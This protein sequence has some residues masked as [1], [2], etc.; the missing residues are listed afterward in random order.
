MKL[1]YDILV[2][3]GGHA[4]AE[5]AWA[6]SRLGAATA[7]ITLSPTR[8]GQMSCNPA[9]GG[10]AKGQMVREIDALGGLMGIA[11]DST[12]IQFR[13]L[14]RSKGPAVWGPR[15]Q[16]DKYKYATE[17]QRLLATCP[18]LDIIAGE[19]ADIEV[20]E[21]G[22]VEDADPTPS[23]RSRLRTVPTSETCEA[24]TRLSSSKSS[25]ED[26]ASRAKARHV[27]GVILADGTKLSCRAAIITTG[28]FLR[29]LMHTGER[30]TEGGRV[31]EAAA[32][33]L[34]GCLTRLGLE[35]GR[36][37]TGTPPRLQ[38]DTI[39][40]AAFEAQP[41]DDEPMPFS[42]LNE[43]AEFEEDAGTRGRWNAET[44]HEDDSALLDSFPASPCPRVSASSSLPVSLP[45]QSRWLPPLQQVNCW[46]G[47]T[48][49]QIH[50]I[51][52]A[53]LHRAPMYSGQIQST[54]PRYCPSIEDKVVR[55]ADKEKHQIF[56]EPEGLD[57][58]EIYCNGISTSLPAD[59]Q[60]QI[61]RLVPGLERAKI[62]RHGYAVEYDMVWPT[63]IRSTLQTKAIRGLYL[64]GQI[65]GTSGYEEAA[66]QGLMAGVNAARYAAGNDTEFVLRRDQAYI[67]VLID[68]L[69]TKPPI[70]PYRMFTS[71]AEHRLHLRS[72]N[73]DE[74]LTPLGRELGLVGDDR[75]N[76]FNARHDAIED[77]ITLLHSAR[78]DG[79]S[80]FD[81]LRKSEVT[82]NE[83][84]AKFP[85]AAAIPCDI[86]RLIE[87]RAK[88]QGYIA[89]QDKQIERSAQWETKLIPASIDYKAV[90]G[91]RNE[92]RQKLTTFTPRSLGQALRIS[93]ITP[94]DVT[95][96]AVHL[97]RTRRERD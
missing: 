42:F 21:S 12:G 8:V 1:N 61:V 27:T 64:A 16:A 54:G 94:A 31:G 68:D 52:R 5:A 50:E 29:A 69:V 33:G 65:N 19:V 83:M 73:A 36:L 34:S 3:G 91:L 25:G 48:S 9:I 46:I 80:A 74:R 14:N 53:N 28:T 40:F 17:V 49:P 23:S 15:A 81:F 30:K 90:V 88:Y 11:T 77:G 59:V 89:R 24:A 20:C 39:D 43:Y 13:M 70:E 4:G 67:G 86:G 37:K 66:A 57:T 62:L 82:W 85:A 56:L 58:D 45:T 84:T 35:L 38:R 87:I 78:A 10:L 92:A 32:K 2:I 18:G 6:A 76:R 41:G 75:W 71:R 47:W 79:M 55:F 51:I 96:L 7:L 95:V 22:E 72:D 60:E 63:Q 93:G 26:S 97:G 44:I